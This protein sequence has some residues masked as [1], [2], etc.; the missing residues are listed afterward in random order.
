MPR[1]AAMAMQDQKWAAICKTLRRFMQ[2]T[3]KRAGLSGAYFCAAYK[4]CRKRKFLCNAN[5]L[6]ICRS[7][8]LR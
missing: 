5:Y 7:Y 6:D 4:K 8:S 3:Q 2:M 1:T